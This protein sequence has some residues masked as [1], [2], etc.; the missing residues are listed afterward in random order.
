MFFSFHSSMFMLLLPLV[1]IHLYHMLQSPNEIQ[2]SITLLHIKYYLG[3]G[4]LEKNSFNLLWLFISVFYLSR[5]F[6]VY[7]HGFQRLI[8]QFQG[9]IRI[10]EIEWNHK[11]RNRDNTKIKGITFSSS[12]TTRNDYSERKRKMWFRKKTKIS[13]AR[14]TLGGFITNKSIPTHIK[15]QIIRTIVVVKLFCLYSS[16]LCAMICQALGQNNMLFVSFFGFMCT[17]TDHLKFRSKLSYTLLLFID[18]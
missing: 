13:S 3:T 16:V 9:G 2:N 6:A 14:C 1:N 7:F 4:K 10:A 17:K 18:E 15:Q 5:S 8:C 11:K 12:N